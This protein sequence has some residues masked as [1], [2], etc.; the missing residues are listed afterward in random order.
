MT[1]GRIKTG[2]RLIENE[3]LRIGEQRPDKGEPPLHP[4]GERSN[5]SVAFVT[6]RHVFQQFFDTPERFSDAL[7]TRVEPHIFE[8]GQFFIERVLL[9]DHPDPFFDA[10]RVSR[11]GSKPNTRR[12]PPDRSTDP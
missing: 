9:W 7:E 5:L 10:S 2:C 6:E 11:R 12:S 4:A 3:Q 1:N 8:H